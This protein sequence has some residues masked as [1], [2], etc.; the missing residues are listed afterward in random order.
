MQHVL[1]I[2]YRAELVRL[3]EFL[4]SGLQAVSFPFEVDSDAVVVL[5]RCF[6]TNDL[7]KEIHLAVLL[8]QL[9]S[10][11]NAVRQD[12]ELDGGVEISEFEEKPKI[13]VY[14]L[15]KHNFSVQLIINIF[16]LF[17]FFLSI[18]LS[19]SHIHTQKNPTHS[20]IYCK[21]KISDD[22]KFSE[23]C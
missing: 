8:C 9:E 20:H 10:L 21:G 3:N 17:P 16:A 12:Q 23:S 19:L 22:L 5:R 4:P 15:I 13:K 6:V 2:F 7:G 18:S 11:V 1:C 14:N